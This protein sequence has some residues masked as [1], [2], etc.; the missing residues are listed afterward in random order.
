MAWLA[1]GEFIKYLYMP[2]VE[3]KSLNPRSKM[4]VL[5]WLKEEGE[6]FVRLEPILYVETE[7][8]VVEVKAPQTGVLQKKLIDEGASVVVGQ[9]LAIFTEPGER[10]PIRFYG[11]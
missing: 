8:G 9:P 3:I 2:K 6:I 1:P 10:P 7:V 4:K 5:A 11:G